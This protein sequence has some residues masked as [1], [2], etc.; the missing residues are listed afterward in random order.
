MFRFRGLPPVERNLVFPELDERILRHP[1]RGKRRRAQRRL[2]F[3]SVKRRLVSL[4]QFDGSV[5][6]RSIRLHG[7]PTDTDGF[8]R[9]RQN[10]HRCFSSEQRHLV[11][12]AKFK[13]RVRRGAVWRK[14]R[15][16]GFRRALKC[17]NV[18]FRE[19]AGSIRRKTVM[20][21][22]FQCETS[23]HNCLLLT[24]CFKTI[25]YSLLFDDD[26]RQPIRHDDDFHNLLTVYS[27]NFISLIK[28]TQ[29]TFP[30]SIDSIKAM[31]RRKS[32]RRTTN[33]TS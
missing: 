2:R 24:A 31:P 29:D 12:F 30:S 33:L 4:K 11:L 32:F 15:R 23:K 9:R 16:A 25:G 8:R 19:Q 22:S 21:S 14:R 7:R 10:G 26:I 1:V 28:F 13:R 27:A 6:R 17:R 20:N 3:S 18:S 5:C